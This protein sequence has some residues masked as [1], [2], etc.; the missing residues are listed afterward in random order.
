[1]IWYSLLGNCGDVQQ[2]WLQQAP[3]EQSK[4]DYMKKREDNWVMNDWMS[5]PF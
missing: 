3:N 2:N 5:F 1:M 4:G